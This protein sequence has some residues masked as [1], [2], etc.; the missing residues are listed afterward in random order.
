MND[1][2]RLDRLQQLAEKG[3][4]CRE[5]VRGKGIRLYETTREGNKLDI[6]E[7]IDDFLRVKGYW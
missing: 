6:R 4:I 1:T 2:E 5:S 7:A 3:F